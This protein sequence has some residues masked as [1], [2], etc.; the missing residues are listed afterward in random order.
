MHVVPRKRRCGNP[1]DAV[2]QLC[3]QILRTGLEVR[4]EI[5]QLTLNRVRVQL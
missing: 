5:I 4:E 3:I 1:D 2:V